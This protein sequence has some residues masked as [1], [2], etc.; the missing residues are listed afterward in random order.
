M[1]QISK[2]LTYLWHFVKEENFLNLKIPEK[3][4]RFKNALKNISIF[5]AFLL[6]LDFIEMQ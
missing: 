1:L 4:D 2:S 6:Q 3:T 5:A